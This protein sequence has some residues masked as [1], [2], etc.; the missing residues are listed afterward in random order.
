[1][2]APALLRVTQH[3]SLFVCLWDDNGAPVTSTYRDDGDR[4]LTDVGLDSD[5]PGEIGPLPPHLFEQLYEIAFDPPS[6]WGRHARAVEFVRRA[7]A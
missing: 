2:D 5:V 6:A 1:M 4:Q 7:A 3:G